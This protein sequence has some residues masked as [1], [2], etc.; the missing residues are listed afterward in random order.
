M[1]S[2]FHAVRQC[3]APLAAVGMLCLLAGCEEPVPITFAEFMDDDIARDGTLARCNED[4]DATAGDIEC[5]NARR[6]AAAIALREERARREALELESEQKLAQLRA[7]VERERAAAREAQL[8]AEAAARA[9]YEAQWN[10]GEVP[11]VDA[12]GMP[13]AAGTPIGI[14]GRPVRESAQPAGSDAESAQAPGV[15][16]LPSSEAPAVADPAAVPAVQ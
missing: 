6:A 4:R 11:A 2:S 7:E 16:G 9:A 14:D 8:L 3:C 12:D 5:A 15:D 1:I 13:V 10:G